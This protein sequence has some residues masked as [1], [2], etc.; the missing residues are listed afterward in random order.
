MPNSM[1]YVHVAAPYAAVLYVLGENPCQV[2]GL[3]LNYVVS[4]WDLQHL[5]MCRALFVGM[6]CGCM[7][8]L[9]Q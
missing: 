6:G 2:D 3:N 7:S 9:Q 1:L 5:D 4:C 8:V